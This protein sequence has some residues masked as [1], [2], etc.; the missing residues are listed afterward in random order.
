MVQCRNREAS[1]LLLLLLRRGDCT[2]G[3]IGSV[4]MEMPS[5]G[6]K[7]R[8]LKEE[9]E[10]E[11]EEEEEMRMQ[12]PVQMREEEGSCIS[13]VRRGSCTQWRRAGAAATPSTPITTQDWIN[14]RDPQQVGA[15][16]TVTGLEV[17]DLHWRGIVKGER[18]YGLCRI[19]V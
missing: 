5:G 4:T 16:C 6:V 1:L 18:G 10:E 14:G 8:S 7:G 11:E 2:E 19:H 3:G 12:L 9:I 13:G 17:E 15:F